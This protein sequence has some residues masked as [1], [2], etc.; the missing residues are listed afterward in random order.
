M[1]AS[2]KKPF[3]YF[4]MWKTSPQFAKMI[5]V[6]GTKMFK[7][8]NKLKSIKNALKELDKTGFSDIQA[9]EV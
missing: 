4:T 9:A 2:G 5:D 6:Q 8:V 3:K 1:G 7:I